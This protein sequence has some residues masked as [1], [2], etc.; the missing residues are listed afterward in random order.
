M[1]KQ[2]VCVKCGKRFP[3]IVPDYASDVTCFRCAQLEHERQDAE[4]K[5]KREVSNEPRTS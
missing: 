5:K 2:A 4:A 1:G 3:A